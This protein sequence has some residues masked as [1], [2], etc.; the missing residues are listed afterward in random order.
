MKLLASW[1]LKVYDSIFVDLLSQKI[2]GRLYSSG[3]TQKKKSMT[4]QTSL[5]P[6]AQAQKKPVSHIS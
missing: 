5:S 4:S 1:R 3:T 6:E 2:K